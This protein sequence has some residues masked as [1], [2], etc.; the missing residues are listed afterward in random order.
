MENYNGLEGLEVST[1][2]TQGGLMETMF[3][4]EYMETLSTYVDCLNKF[5]DKYGHLDHVSKE[6]GNAMISM[7]GEFILGLRDTTI[8]YSIDSDGN[9]VGTHRFCKNWVVKMNLFNKD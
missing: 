9:L 8:K 2:L 1:E 4:A 3:V 7:V 5:V 6:F